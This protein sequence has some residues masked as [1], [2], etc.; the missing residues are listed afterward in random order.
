MREFAM[1]GKGKDWIMRTCHELRQNMLGIMSNDR[2]KIGW[3]LLWALGVPIPVLLI[4]FAI[5]GCT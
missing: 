4:L 3:I 5:R 1:F 2:G